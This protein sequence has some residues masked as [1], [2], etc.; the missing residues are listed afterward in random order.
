MPMVRDVDRQ[1]GR[2]SFSTRALERSPGDMLTMNPQ[3]VYRR[4]SDLCLNFGA[5]IEATERS[6][7]NMLLRLA[8]MEEHERP[9][10]L[11]KVEEEEDDVVQGPNMGSCLPH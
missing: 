5:A 1:S 4:A 8:S 7:S 2:V 6:L 10:I 11:F 9:R 3:D